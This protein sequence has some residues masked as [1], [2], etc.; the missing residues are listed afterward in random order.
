MLD[1]LYVIENHFVWVCLM[2]MTC[3]DI[4]LQIQTS[5]TQLKFIYLHVLDMLFLVN[6]QYKNV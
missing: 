2:L 3:E 4:D 1:L 6:E 5:Y